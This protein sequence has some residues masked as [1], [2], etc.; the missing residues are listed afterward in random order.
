VRLETLTIVADRLP[1]S[2]ADEPFSGTVIS[3]EEG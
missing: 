1:V 2:A 3:R